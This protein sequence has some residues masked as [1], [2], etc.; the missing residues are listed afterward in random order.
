MKNPATSPHPLPCAV[1]LGFAGSRRLFEQPP[2]DPVKQAELDSRVERYLIDMLSQLPH[3]LELH[4]NHFLVGMSQIACGADLLFTRACLHARPQSI[5]QRIILPQHRQA[6]LLATD[7]D[8]IADFSADERAQAVSLLNESHIIQERVVSHSADRTVQFM[9]A[10]AELLRVSDVIVCLLRAESSGKPGGTNEL[11]DRAKVRG[12]P[13]LEIRVGLT[14]GEPTFNRAWHNLGKRWSTGDQDHPFCRPHLP[15]ALAHESV[16]ISV[17]PLPTVQEFCNPL[18]HLVST[19]AKQHQNLFKFAAVAIITTHTLATIF[20]TLAVVLHKAGGDPGTAAN[21][22]SLLD[23]VLLGIEVMLLLAGFGVHSNLHHSQAAR[24]WAI[25]RVVAELA[26]SLQ[27]IG[28][29]HVYLKH[30]FFLPLPYSFRPL[31]RTLNILHLRSTWPERNTEWKPQRDAYIR[32]RVDDQIRFYE[33][34]LVVDNR[35]LWWCQSTFTICSILAI[36][37]TSVKF[38]LTLLSSSNDLLLSTLGTLAIVLP[39]LAVGGL[40]WSAAL[41]CEARVE[42]FIETLRFLERQRPFFEQATTVTEFDRLLLETESV[43]LGETANWF[44]R[45]SNTSVT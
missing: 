42:T 1:Q 12:V 8:G 23:P 21:G 6:Y 38:I 33:R 15:H 13:V 7:S 31:L 19:Q 25:A 22:H 37:A 44:S 32:N 9:D 39:V 4:P 26:R 45:R 24:T 27:A 2:G 34:R 10:S 18:K 11:L 30:L 16:R 40:S 28:P 29:H 36:A 41:D 20:A 5:P 35:R 17:E 43:L 14:S 3:E